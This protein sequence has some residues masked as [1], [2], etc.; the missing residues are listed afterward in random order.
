M[1][2]P[3]CWVA[4]VESLMSTGFRPTIGVHHHLLDRGT[5]PAA[6]AVAGRTSVSC[7]THH[8]LRWRPRRRLSCFSASNSS[9]VSTPDF[10]RASSLASSSAVLTLASTSCTHSGTA[11]LPGVYRQARRQHLGRTFPV[12][13]RTKPR[14]KKVT[15]SL[16]GSKIQPS[17][18]PGLV[19][20][21]V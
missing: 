21:V 2:L 19:N 10:L 6:T 8:W 7:R 9:W 4:A 12:P 11:S 3:G 18:E 5:T 15:A 1:F 16:K 20:R 17:G 13:T 14:A